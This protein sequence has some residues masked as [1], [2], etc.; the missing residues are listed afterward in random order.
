MIKQLCVALSLLVFACG[1]RSTA[2]QPSNLVGASQNGTNRVDILVALQALPG[3][4]VTEVTPRVTGARSFDI[5]IEQQ[6]DHTVAADAQPAPATFKQRIRLLH[7]NEDAPMVLA[8]S[9][10]H[11]GSGRD[12]ELSRMLQAN[13][14][15]V[16]QRFFG[17]S[18]PVP[19][20]W[21]HL[22]IKQAATD[23]H[24]IV[25]TF[26]SIY[27]KAWLSTGASKGGMASIYHRRFFPDDVTA[28]VAYVAPQSY[29]TQD[30]RYNDFLENVGTQ[31]CRDKISAFQ[32]ELLS[33]RDEIVPIFA[34]AALEQHYTFAR[35]GSLEVAVEFAIQEF[36]FALWQYGPSNG[37]DTL[38]GAGASAAALA[39]TLDK[40]ASPAD[41]GGDQALE[42]YAAFYYQI[43]NELGYYGPLERHLTDLLRFSGQY[44]NTNFT[45]QAVSYDATVMPSVQR[46][47][48]SAGER[49]LIIYGEN[50]PWSAGAFTVK[51]AADSAS[52]V[53][54]KGNHGA[55]IGR[56]ATA[57]QQTIREMLSRWT[58]SL[59]RLPSTPS[60]DEP[61]EV[62]R[63]RHDLF[64]LLR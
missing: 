23:H 63:P 34:Q 14:L 42:H 62:E 30:A 25:D 36:R 43:A 57:E 46:W 39:E 61:S 38:P 7:R 44:V 60:R 48:S 3:V 45:P 5:T 32:R 1:N 35:V 59:V 12:N 50:D 51:G 15:E 13:V 20:T 4:T 24:H 49:V 37:C 19:T 18:T 52:F 16:E 28:T 27:G 41:I 53:V 31:A 54:L 9:G 17:A 29:S 26:K 11:L 55:G 6:V 40:W 22:T 56:L 33:R 2:A 21:Q 8:T 64:H 10:Y 58:G 47:L